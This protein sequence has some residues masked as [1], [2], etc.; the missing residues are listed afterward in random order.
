MQLTASIFEIGRWSAHL[1]DEPLKHLG[2]GFARPGLGHRDPNAVDM[3]E[4]GSTVNEVIVM[5]IER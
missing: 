5:G 4:R 2:N 3:R 1:S